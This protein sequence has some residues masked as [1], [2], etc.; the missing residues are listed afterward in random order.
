MEKTTLNKAIVLDFWKRAIGQRD[1]S[2]AEKLVSE[3]YIQ[4]SAA[5]K[6]G[7]AGLME[8]LA[9]LSQMPKPENQPKPK[10]Q[11]IADGDYVAVHMLIEF[12]GQH[13]IIVD[14]VRLERGL[15]TEH[16]DAVELVSPVN[17][18]DEYITEANT[19][20]SDEHLTEANKTV[21]AD[22]HATH[23]AANDKLHRII[24][25]GN[26]VVT[27]S[28]AGINHVPHVVYDIYKLSNGEIVEH[29]SAKQIIPE[30]MEHSN[31]MV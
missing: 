14:L 9:L 17:D 29:W 21:I 16:W 31:G 11:V 22:F 1:L 23:S 2:V 8:S 12:R 30:R 28:T 24:G 25:E 3:N 7:K 20:I 27:Q 15:L 5:G 19:R 4:H 13:M 26:L 18:R 10:M 6:P